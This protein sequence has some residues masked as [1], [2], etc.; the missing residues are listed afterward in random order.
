MTTCVGPD[1][2][3]PSLLVFVAV[4]SYPISNKLFPGQTARMKAIFDTR[5]ENGKFVNELRI[6]KTIKSKLPPAALSFT[7][8]R[9]GF[10]LQGKIK[11]VY[12]PIYTS[13]QILKKR[14]GY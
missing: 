1:G 4:P 8:S 6:Q 10:I 9:S 13:K 5:S 14:L 2:L 11:N 3:G 7:G 12:W